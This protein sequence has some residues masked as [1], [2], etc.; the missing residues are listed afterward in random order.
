MMQASP[1]NSSARVLTCFP[2]TAGHQYPLTT[3]YL[4]VTLHAIV[5][6]AFNSGLTVKD[7]E[8]PLLLGCLTFSQAWV[9]RPPQC[10]CHALL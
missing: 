8:L 2:W 7:L 3:H 9:T 1:L 4:S 6:I 5:C 10:S